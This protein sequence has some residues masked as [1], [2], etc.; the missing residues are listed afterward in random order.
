MRGRIRRQLPVLAVIAAG[1]VLGAEAR[2]ALSRLQDDPPGWPW[3]TVAENVSGCLLIGVL[4]AV[5]LE[6]TA[7]HRLVR[8]FLGVGLL[9]GYTTFSA[10]AVEVQHMLVD[11]RYI[12]A[13]I[14]LAVTPLAAVLA[15]WFASSSTRAALGRLR[16]RDGRGGDGGGAA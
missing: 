8:P 11:E 9:G 10:Y 6:L 12:S 5:L 7:P 2:Y 3:A 13:L 1:G 14:Y 16:G 4:M 15:V